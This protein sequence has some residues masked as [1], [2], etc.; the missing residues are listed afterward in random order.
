[1]SE[2]KITKTMRYEIE[3]NKELYDILSD[4]QYAVWRI[5][6]KATSMAWDWQ[7]FSFG[8]NERFGEWPKEKDVLGKTLSP[9][10][11]AFTKEFGAHV[12][13]ATVDTATQD[14]VKKFKNDRSE[15]RRVGKEYET[16]M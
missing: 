8:Y 6:N 2:I 5:K 12:A 15:E 10:V 13:S 9:D 3:Y 1:M 14:A 11:Y 7:Q 4:I 16:A